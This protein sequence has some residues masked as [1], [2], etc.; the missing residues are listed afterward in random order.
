M[1]KYKLITA[2]LF[3]LLS[4]S[5]ITIVKT[6]VGF[7]NPKVLTVNEIKSI[8]KETFKTKAITDLY[9]KGVKDSTAIMDVIAN[10]FNGDIL[11]F[12]SKGKQK[13]LAS[14]STCSGIQLTELETKGSDLITDCEIESPLKI[15]E[16]LKNT[17]YINNDKTVDSSHFSNKAYTFVYYWSSFIS[18]KK[19]MQEDFEYF[20]SR[21]KKSK[22]AYNIIRINC[23]LNETW[24]LKKG[25]K[26]KLSFQKVDKR[27][28][29]L[30]FG[31]IPWKN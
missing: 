6:V 23:D 7:K 21:L 24:N 28:Y 9:Y 25:K 8:T 12:D 19:R 22:I 5:C 26:I 18:S 27:K 3:V 16:V 14:Q 1:K 15:Q 10:S 2:V 4:S 20:E 17:F 30:T 13:C 31:K 29:D 11:V